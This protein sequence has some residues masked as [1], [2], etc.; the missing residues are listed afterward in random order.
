MLT[1]IEITRLLV[2]MLLQ[3]METHLHGEGM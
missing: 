2:S 1:Y 3:T